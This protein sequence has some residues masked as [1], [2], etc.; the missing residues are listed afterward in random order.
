MTVEQHAESRR[1]LGEVGV[2]ESLMRLLTVVGEEGHPVVFDA[3]ESQEA[4]EGFLTRLVAVLQ[5]LG[6]TMNE[7]QTCTP[8]V[9]PVM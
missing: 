3:W 7:P 2:S 5:D 4:W 6:V 8:T 1:R 9:D